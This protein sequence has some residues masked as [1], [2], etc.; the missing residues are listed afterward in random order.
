MLLDTQPENA[1]LLN[2]LAWVSGRQK[3]PGAID[4]AEKANKL[5]PNQPAFMDTLGVLLAEKGE[6]ARGLEL[7]AKAVE[8]APQAAGIRL[9]YAGMLIKADQKAE[10]KKQLDELTKLGDKFSGQAEVAQMVK[11]L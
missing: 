2:N 7:L 8:L 10:A 11:D 1:V 9:N 6:M 3:L 4:F 5:A